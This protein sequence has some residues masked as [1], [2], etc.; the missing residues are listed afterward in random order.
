M[1]SSAE[2]KRHFPRQRY[3]WEGRGL[4]DYFR[5]PRPAASLRAGGVPVTVTRFRFRWPETSR[6]PTDLGGLLVRTCETAGGRVFAAVVFAPVGASRRRDGP[7]PRAAQAGPDPGGRAGVLA[8]AGLSARGSY[9]PLRG[10]YSRAKSS[11]AK[12]DTERAPLV[13]RARASPGVLREEWQGWGDGLLPKMEL[14]CPQKP[15]SELERSLATPRGSQVRPAR[16]V[17]STIQT[18]LRIFPPH[19]SHS[20]LPGAVYAR[21]VPGARVC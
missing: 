1:S 19:Q 12:M 8:R 17:V 6:R 15:G 18:L 5:V 4:G 2:R 13:I 10:S 20:I 7:V 21:P 14:N 9:R 16:R 11:T 3:W